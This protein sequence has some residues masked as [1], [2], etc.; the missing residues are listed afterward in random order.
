MLRR[1]PAQPLAQRIIAIGIL[2]PSTPSLPS[3]SEAGSEGK[4]G[5]GRPRKSRKAKGSADRE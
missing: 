4:R 5:S 1:E 3:K 2:E